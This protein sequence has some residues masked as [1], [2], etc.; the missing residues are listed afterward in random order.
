MVCVM[1]L[2]MA[3]MVSGEIA[4]GDA[5]LND[6]EMLQNDQGVADATDEGQDHGHDC[7]HYLNE[8]IAGIELNVAGPALAA[9]VCDE[10][11]RL[12]MRTMLKLM[13]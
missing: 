2:V 7:V 3:R 6:V 9:T 12:R 5:P 13:S 8:G 11:G 10:M 1:E 4:Q